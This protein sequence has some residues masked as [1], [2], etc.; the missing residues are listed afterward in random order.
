MQI[1]GLHKS[2]YK[3][4]SYSRKQVELDA[5]YKK[6]ETIVK[7]WDTF[8]E[9]GLSDKLLEEVVGCSR[10]TY[11]RAKK[12]LSNFKQGIKPLSKA[13]KHQNKPLWGESEKQL[14]LRLR[15]E[16]PTYGKTKLARILHRDH[17]VNLSESTVG[18][19]LRFLF[20]KGLI[21]R[22]ISA[23]RKKRMRDFSKGYA[24]RWTYK[25]YKNIK[26]GE[27]V[28]ID[29]MSVT[30]HGVCLKHFQ[31]WERKSRYIHAQVYSDAKSRSA[32]RFLEE[33][34]E[35]A[36]YPILSIQVDGGS[37]FMGEFEQ[38]CKELGI[39]LIVLPPSQPRYNG[40][41]E[42]G[43]RIFREEFYDTAAYQADSIGAARNELK[44]ALHKY[45]TY[46][47]H[48]GLSGATPMEYLNSLNL[49][50]IHKVSFSLN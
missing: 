31:A 11:Y 2:L 50:T 4:Y 48:H 47:P 16:N 12:I 36:P 46:R 7:Q 33:L 15:R 24:K 32:K 41:V 3:L 23:F 20:K 13:R 18:R 44:K 30:R 37:E 22:S 21:I 38:A 34:C 42:R 9:K 25:D 5:Y 6:Y 29:H 17:N 43:N 27:R 49:G 28:Q 45:N 40:G 10:A 8:K 14:V 26:L 39:K 19:I 1:R 35:K